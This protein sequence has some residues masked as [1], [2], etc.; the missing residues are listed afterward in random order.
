MTKDD[1]LNL[2][3]QIQS[4]YHKKLKELELNLAS[5]HKELHQVEQGMKHEEKKIYGIS[6]FATLKAKKGKLNAAIFKVKKDIKNL[7]KEKI[8]K[9]NKLKKS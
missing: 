9:I 1:K 8:K 7:N 6:N 3:H 4:E 5:L 2:I